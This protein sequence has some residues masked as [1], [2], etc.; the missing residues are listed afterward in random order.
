[1]HNKDKNMKINFEKFK[2][3]TSISHK[4]AQTTDVR[5]RF[6]DMIY[7]GINGIRAQVLAMKIFK[8]NGS[9]E[10]EPEE[11]KLIKGIAEQFCVPG[12]I[13]GLNEQLNCQIDKNE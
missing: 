13:D 10:Y 11:I 3:Y 12:F 7:T 5:E 2:V 4:T 8:S 6:A 9:V 1:M